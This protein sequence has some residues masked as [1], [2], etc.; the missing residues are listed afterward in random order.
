[1][2]SNGVWSFEPSRNVSVKTPRQ[3]Q[4][5]KENKEQIMN[6]FLN[7]NNKNI[8]ICIDIK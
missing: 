2:K 5:K 6:V 8:Y 7:K 3:I 4:A 1:M